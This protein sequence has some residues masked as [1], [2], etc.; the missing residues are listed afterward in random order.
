MLTGRLDHFGVSNSNFQI[1]LE[2][3]YVSFRVWIPIT[4]FSKA[5]V[6][7][8]YKVLISVII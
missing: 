3:G 1:N 7:T 8:L 4:G 6:E 2:A 5:E